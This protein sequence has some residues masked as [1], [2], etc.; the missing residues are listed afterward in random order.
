MGNNLTI[1]PVGAPAP[2]AAATPVSRAAVD[3]VATELPPSQSVTAGDAAAGAH[4]DAQTSGQLLAHQVTLD[5]EAASIVYRTIDE[6]TNAVI[7]QFPDDPTLRRR[8]YFRALEAQK[9]SQSPGSA[10]DRKA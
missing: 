1:R 10:T 2:V 9:A 3:A 4:L 5:R 8:A 7:S 6:R